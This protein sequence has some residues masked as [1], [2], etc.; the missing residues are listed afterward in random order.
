L[1]FT[2]LDDF[3][4]EQ[5]RRKLISVRVDPK[6]HKIAKELGLKISKI[7]EKALK[8][9][10]LLLNASESTRECIMTPERV[11]QRLSLVGPPGFEP[12]SREPKSQSLDHASRRPPL[13]EN[14]KSPASSCG[15]AIDFIQ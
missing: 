12:E 2:D 1:S 13:Y 3:V 5:M 7:C 11:S 9:Q 4:E 6:I 15:M 14:R 10:I 8:Q